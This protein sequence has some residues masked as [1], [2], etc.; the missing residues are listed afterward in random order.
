LKIQP[1]FV[2]ILLTQTGNGYSGELKTIASRLLCGD[3]LWIFRALVIF[4][5]LC[6][7]RPIV[8]ESDAPAVVW[9]GR[10]SYSTSAR[11]RLMHVGRPGGSLI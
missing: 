6:R 1:T 5:T 7:R 3:D 2:E 11:G 4:V 9:L 8:A 10:W